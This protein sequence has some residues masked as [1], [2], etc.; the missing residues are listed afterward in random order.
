MDFVMSV[1]SK[2][3]AYRPSRSLTKNIKKVLEIP[4]SV[5]TNANRETQF[6]PHRSD[7][8]R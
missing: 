7:L 5:G 2:A 3:G 4:L 1:S 6:A 8:A